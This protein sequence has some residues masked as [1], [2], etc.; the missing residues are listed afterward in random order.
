M[1]VISTQARVAL[2]LPLEKERVVLTALK[3]SPSAWYIMCRESKEER[4]TLCTTLH[5]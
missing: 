4:V 1:M 3:S 2:R 5:S